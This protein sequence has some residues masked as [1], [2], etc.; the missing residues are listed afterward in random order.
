MEINKFIKVFDDTCSPKVIASFVK[1]LNKLEFYK[2]KLVGGIINKKI[3]STKEYLFEPNSDKLTDVHWFWFWQKI[4]ANNLKQYASQ[5]KYG[6]STTG[7]MSLSALKYEVGDFY[8]P[9]TDYHSSFPR[10]L[11]I[12]YF[13]NNDYEGG[14]IF[15]QNPFTGEDIIEVGSKP[16]RLLVWPSNFIFPHRVDKVT[17]GRRNVLV[18]WWT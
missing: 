6:C 8:I 15:F 1:Y 10:N 11:S 17:K 7:M 13:L 4:F 16:G 18:S 3:R 12:I 2:A 5:F 9:H 14:H